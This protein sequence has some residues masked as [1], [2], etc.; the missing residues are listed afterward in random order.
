MTTDLVLFME[1][2]ARAK[3]HMRK[4]SKSISSSK[5]GKVLNNGLDLFQ[6]HPQ[7]DAI[8]TVLT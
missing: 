7:F 2:K 5:T 4:R 3:T 6:Q 8:T 1:V